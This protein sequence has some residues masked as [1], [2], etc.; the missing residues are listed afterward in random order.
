MAC[1]AT[2]FGYR[3]LYEIPFIPVG[4]SDLRGGAKGVDGNKA[5]EAGSPISGAADR[6][7]RFQNYI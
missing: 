1:L 5:L 6:S 3:R 4:L 2:V 7:I